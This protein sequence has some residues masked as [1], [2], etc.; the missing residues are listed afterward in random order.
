MLGKYLV[1]FCMMKALDALKRIDL[2]SFGVHVLAARVYNCQFQYELNSH[3]VKK[4]IIT[5]ILNSQ[6]DF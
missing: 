2:P 1:R 3:D 4:I 6:N 5:P